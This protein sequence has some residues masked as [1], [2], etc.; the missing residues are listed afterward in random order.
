M[1]MIEAER[2]TCL[3]K[4]IIWM[5]ARSEIQEVALVVS[6]CSLLGTRALPRIMGKE[7]HQPIRSKAN[8]LLI[9][10]HW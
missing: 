7:Y 4:H 6:P 9:R 8:L 3:L 10:L 1:W 2:L 5:K